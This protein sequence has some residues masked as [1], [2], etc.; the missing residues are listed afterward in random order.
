M[1]QLRRRSRSGHSSSS[2]RALGLGWL[3]AGE[4]LD[5][6]PADYAP[7]PASSVGHAR[8]TSA[9]RV[10]P[11]VNSRSLADTF[12]SMLDRLQAAFRAQQGF[13]ARGLA[14]IRTPLA[15]IR[16]EA[17]LV[18]D[19]PALPRGKPGRGSDSDRR[20]A[21]P[22]PGRWAAGPRPQREHAVEPA[23]IDLADVAGDVVGEP[24]PRPIMPGI[25]SISSLESATVLATITPQR[26]VANLVQN[27]I[28]YNLPGRFGLGGV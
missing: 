3:I 13:A 27:A 21:Q 23:N 11:D 20:P 15:I 25:R 28:R 4:L 14:R 12:D 16:A 2:R 24:V 9:P 1:R 18:R 5:P 8:R 19:T 10:V 17:E 6:L 26:M 22:E 7:C